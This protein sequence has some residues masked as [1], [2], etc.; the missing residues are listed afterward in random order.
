[1]II[2]KIPTLLLA[3]LLCIGCKVDRPH[4]DGPDYIMFSAESHDLGILD[5]E[6]WFEIPVSAT[7]ATNYE[8]TI[9]VEI[10]DRES[11]A[12]E[13]LHYTLESNTLHIK[14]GELTTAVRIKGNPES[15]ALTDSLGI[16]LRLVLDDEN[17]WEQYGTDTQ[18]HLHKCCPVDMNLFTGYCKITS[19][20]LMQYMGTDARLAITELASDE[21]NTIIIRDLFYD[22]YDMR[23]KFHTDDRLNPYIDYEPLMI[24]TTGEAFGTIYGNGQLMMMQPTG[25]T[26]YFSS[27]EK[28]MVQYATIYVEEVGTVGTYVHIFEW[29]SNDE[30]ERI[31]REGF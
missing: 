24:G 9:G 12:I 31:M 17:V 16:T 22:G 25:Y 14:A 27:C 8:R 13:G 10:V 1:M 26:S 5:S 2:R 18:V 6:E 29:I 19:T 15:I 28:F 30:A 20:W 4:Y 11:N 3:V 7:R 23:V 21:Q